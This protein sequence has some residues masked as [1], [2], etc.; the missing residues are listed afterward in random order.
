MEKHLRVYKACLHVVFDRAKLFG[1][2]YHC[3]MGPGW[4]DA[5][6]ERFNHKRESGTYACGSVIKL[7]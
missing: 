3:A 2:K 5:I 1:H 4:L 6:K 7:S